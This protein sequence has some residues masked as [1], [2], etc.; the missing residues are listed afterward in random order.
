MLEAEIQK[1][2]SLRASLSDFTLFRQN[3][4]VAWQG[5]VARIDSSTVI[6]RNARPVHFGLF[7]GSSDLIGWRPITITPEM[8]GK[9]IA[10]FSAIECK[11]LKGTTTEE[12]QN[13]I[14]RVRG[15]GGI[16]FVA[17][18]AADVVAQIRLWITTITTS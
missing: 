1:Q 6:I 12:Q 18:G 9:Q 7:K 11:T 10:V 4:G 17:R 5:D 16:A 8:V 3:T 15:A 2:V 14:D 13:F